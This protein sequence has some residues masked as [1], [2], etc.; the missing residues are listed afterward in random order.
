MSSIETTQGLERRVQLIVP[1]ETV[2][3]AVS[4]ELKRV[5]K[6]AKID[7]FRKGKVP[8][9]MIEKMYGASVRQEVLGELLQ[10]T[11]F[12]EMMKEKVN[13]AGRPTFNI[14]KFEDNKDVEFT[15]TFE[16]YPEIKLKGLETIEVEKPVVEITDADIE[17]MIGVLRKQQANW[18]E[19][20]RVANASDR[21]TID[22][23][24]TINGEEFQG[25]NAE[26]FVLLMGQ[27]RMI[28]GFE[29]GI[30][31]HKAGEKFNIDVTFPEDYQ[32]ENLKGK[33]AVFA[34]N[35]KKVEEMELPELTDEFVAK[36]AAK[37]VAE[38]R[39]EVLKNMQRELNNA[40]KGRIKTQALEGLLKANETDVPTSAVELEVETLRNQAA[41]RYG[42]TKEQA[43]QL[44]SELFQ[45]EAKRRVQIGLLLGTLI[46]EHKLVAD[47]VRVTA[48][49]EEI[50]SA[51]EKPA[52]VVEYY[53]NNAELMNNLRNAVLEEQVI[54]MLLEKAKVTEKAMSFDE[55][56]AQKA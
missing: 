32:S 6:N 39:A 21:V 55:I 41:Q 33:K 31:T 12:E 13:L 18:K 42:M 37:T 27:G 49:L 20:E 26:D 43:T 1:A 23:T 14:D 19:V 53:K 48:M 11:F 29:E 8:A 40:I 36:F 24:G 3:K 10:R 17:K 51:Y 50:A 46:A 30:V 9:T 35:L 52:E 16:V 5:A 4:G 47:E 38:L 2:K 22:F 34:I 7:G 54:D 15:A 56:M 44:P 25:G 28:P 45:A